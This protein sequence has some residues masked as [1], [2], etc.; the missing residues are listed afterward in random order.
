M[1]L[2]QVPVVVVDAQMEAVVIAQADKD[3]DAVA[4]APMELAVDADAI[5]HPERLR[6][7]DEYISFQ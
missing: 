5:A 7:N 6:Q 2:V 3:V 4:N 1:V